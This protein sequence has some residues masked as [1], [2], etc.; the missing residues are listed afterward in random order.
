MKMTNKDD[1]PYSKKDY[2]EAKAQGLDLDDWYD[3]QK[4]YHL[5]EYEEEF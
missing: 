3:Y 4:F 5:G 1:P 2:E